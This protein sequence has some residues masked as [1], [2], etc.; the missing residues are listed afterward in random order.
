MGSSLIAYPKV[1]YTQ[2]AEPT[3]KTAGRLWYKT[4]TKVL[5][6]ADGTD[7]IA[8]GKIA[9]GAVGT[10]EL[11]DG[12]VTEVK[13]ALNTYSLSDVTLIS[14]VAE[15]TTTSNTYVKIKTITLDAGMPVDTPIRIYAGMNTGGSQYGYWRIYRN[16]VAHGTQHSHNNSSYA[17]QS[18]D[19]DFTG[20]DTIELWVH[21]T[22]SATAWFKDFQV[23]GVNAISGGGGGA[24]GST[25]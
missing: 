14:H 21:T 16:G 22:A 13:A 5:Y 1:I 11:A 4:D 25:S 17:Y 12:A 10:A 18:E 19:L 24:S 8:V 7:Y 20:G 3:D 9:A 2:I 23:R 6:T 15:A